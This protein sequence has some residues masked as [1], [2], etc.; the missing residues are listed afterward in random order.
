MAEPLCRHGF[1]LVTQLHQ[2]T[3]DLTDVPPL[4]EMPLRLLPMTPA[5]EAD[6]AQV[7]ARTYT[8]TLDCPE[9]NGVRTIAEI[10]DGHRAQGRFDPEMWWLA[11]D[12]ET[13]IGVVML[14]ELADAVT[15]E[16]A[17]VGIVP[18]ARRH[19]YGRALM[20]HALHA[21]SRRA[22]T[23]MTLSVDARNVP[24]RALYN[25]LGFVE[26]DCSDVLLHISE[27]PA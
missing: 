24:A 10:L 26:I 21:L 1:R 15:W 16:L 27:P 23:A 4:P 19:G 22:A 8:G 17:Y 6:F 12:G 25:R 9:L 7:L 13:P 11:C 3:H 20:V 2:L 5:R 14:V 18:E